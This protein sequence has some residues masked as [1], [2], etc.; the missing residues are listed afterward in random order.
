MPLLLS[1]I[2]VA[3]LGILAHYIGEALPRRL[4]N[5]RKFPY[6]QFRFEKSGR[7]YRFLRVHKWKDKLP[8]MSKVMK[9]MIPKSVSFKPTSAELYR[10]AG[11]TCVAEAV[12]NALN[13]LFLGIYLFWKNRIGIFLTAL[14]IILNSPFIIIQRYNRPKIIS[15]ADRLAEREEKRN[16]CINSVV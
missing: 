7:L 13:I 3:A 15:L 10:L 4:F 11:E 12:H 8:D 14:S 2:Y 5:F 16:A 9:D 6:R 1:I